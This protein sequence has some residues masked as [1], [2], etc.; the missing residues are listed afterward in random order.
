MS[1]PSQIAGKRKS[2]EACEFMGENTLGP[3]VFS[4][5]VVSGVAEVGCVFPQVRGSIWESCR[6]KVHRTAGL[7]L[8]VKNLMRSEHF[9]KMKLA[10]C[11]QDCSESS[12]L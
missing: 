9:W 4:S 6:Q 11:A 12:I 1:T 7:D 10:K 3:Y 8:H 2:S 5:N